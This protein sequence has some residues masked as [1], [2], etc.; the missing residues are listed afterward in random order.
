MAQSKRL[1]LSFLFNIIPLMIAL[2]IIC[3]MLIPFFFMGLGLSQV[4]GQALE[5]AGMPQ[6]N[7]VIFGSMVAF[8]LA[9]IATFLCVSKRHERR[10]WRVWLLFI[11]FVPVLGPLAFLISQVWVL[12]IPQPQ[13]R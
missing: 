6:S 11:L 10:H 9:V 8:G 3:T 12:Q 13:L 1:T 5:Q 7:P 4:I 2:M